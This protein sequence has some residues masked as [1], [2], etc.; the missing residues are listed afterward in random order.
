MKRSVNI[1]ILIFA[2]VFSA[3]SQNMPKD[4][5]KLWTIAEVKVVAK[6]Y[7]FEDSVTLPRFTVLQYLDKKNM[8]YYIKI[9]SE[10]AQKNKQWTEYLKKTQFV[11]TFD[12]YA[13]LVESYPLV[14]Q[15]IVKTRGGEQ[16]HQD[17]I[18]SAKRYR[19]RI[20][21]N[22]D[23]GIGIYRADSPIGSTELQWGQ[24]IDNLPPAKE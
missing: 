8:E 16:A 24:R 9:N 15:A 1:L 12:D 18:A 7:N 19:W 21:R 6:K 10:S 2:F 14:R 20:Y 13:K 3:N 23:G 17:Y 22:T 11:R 4:A 5:K